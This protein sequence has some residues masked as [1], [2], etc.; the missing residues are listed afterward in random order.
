MEIHGEAI[1]IEDRATVETQFISVEVAHAHQL[2]L[3][4]RHSVRPLKSETVE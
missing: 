1:R 4:L 3:G 2:S